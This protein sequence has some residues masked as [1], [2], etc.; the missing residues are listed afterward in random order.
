[1]KKRVNEWPGAVND[2]HQMFREA[3]ADAAA[4]RHELALQK[5]LWFH[6]NALKLQPSLSGVRRSYAL[7]AWRKLADVYPP[8][9]QELRKA[10]DAARRAARSS[11]DAW[12][13]F[14]D[15]LSIKE[16]LGEEIK[17][18]RFFKWL[19]RNAPKKAERVYHG[20][21]EALVR[22]GE[23]ALCGRYIRGE[24]RFKQIRKLYRV[25]LRLSRDPKIGADYADFARRSF[26][27]KNSAAGCLTGAK[28]TRARGKED[29]NPR[30][31]DMG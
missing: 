22:A 17:T 26:S 29:R 13:P 30:E 4:G 6:N 12:H 20:T 1:M 31:T 19:H 21:E 5:H 28:R 23:F 7:S 25:N 8:A 15:F 11:P 16:Y 2:P 3:V 14:A 9:M 18:V 27:E 24:E 10:S